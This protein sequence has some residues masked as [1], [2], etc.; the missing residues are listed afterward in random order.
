[1]KLKK[2]SAAA[3]AYMAKIRSKR[4]TKTT[5]KSKTKQATF[6]P[7]F[8]KKAAKK[9]TMFGSIQKINSQAMLK[10]KKLA[11]IEYNAIELYYKLQ[12]EGSEIKNLHKVL[13]SITLLN[14]FFHDN[15]MKVL[16]KGKLVQH[17]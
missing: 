3:K 12:L 15:N 9:N 11:K 4:K 6:K 10:L 1:M 8:K 7:S 5:T 14:N 13:D 2:G 17:F 16:N